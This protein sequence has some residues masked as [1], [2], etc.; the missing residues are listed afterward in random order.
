[1]DERKNYFMLGVTFGLLAIKP[2]PL[3]IFLF[4]I[5]FVFAFNMIMPKFKQIGKADI[6]ALSWI[7]LGFLIMGYTEL[8][9]F[10]IAFLVVMVI[11]MIVRVIFKINYNTPFFGVLTIIFVLTCVINS[12]I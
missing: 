11:Y 2:A 10:L 1:V 8:F 3:L 4:Y 5:G 7:L 9:I 12:F 6:T